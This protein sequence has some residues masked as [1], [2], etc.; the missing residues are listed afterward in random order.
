MDASA[1]QNRNV[2]A[3]Q[4]DVKRRYERICSIN[5]NTKLKESPRV[6]PAKGSRGQLTRVFK[7]SEPC[8]LESAERR[9]PTAFAD[10]VT[11]E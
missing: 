4:Y 2:C 1:T 9:Q 6:E 5:N 8:Y 3:G 10:M 11:M 7:I